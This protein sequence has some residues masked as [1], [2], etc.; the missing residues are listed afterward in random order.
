LNILCLPLFSTCD[1]IKPLTVKKFLR[2]LKKAALTLLVLLGVLLV[3]I[4][5]FINLSPEF[6]GSA[7]EADKERYARSGRYEEAIF[8][9]DIPT[10]MA[11][12]KWETMLEFF[13]SSPDRQPASNIEVLPVDSASIANP[14]NTTAELIWFGHSTFLLQLDGKNILLDP[15]LGDTPSPHPW[16]GGK[17]YSKELPIEIAELPQIDAVLLSHD[18]YDHLD[19]GSIVELKDKVA[20]FYT[21][22]GVGVHL[23]E[24]GIPE[25]KIHE[26]NWGESL[27]QD[28]TEFICAPARHFSGRGLTDRFATLWG[29]WV[30]AG[31]H[32]KIFF[33][34]DSG[35][36]EHFK[37]IGNKYGP[38]DIALMECGQYNEEWANIHMMP[39]ETVQAAVDV[40]AAVAMPIH[41]GAFTLAL[42]AWVE[43]PVRMAKKAE[44]LGMPIATPKIGERF[45]VGANSY[46]NTA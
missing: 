2:I 35:Y 24:W 14:A 6:G 11:D 40:K 44:E 18:H 13:K 46:P 4:V 32:K 3:Y 39:E 41:W 27:T 28:G 23:R 26:L 1:P 25:E 21:P 22:L 17:R 16:V 5:L 34:G 8:V 20:H 19:Y 7:T 42:H 9:N 12:P 33:S 30:I 38:F 45:T 36:G 10:P 15:M 37:E 29:S 31:Q 43:P